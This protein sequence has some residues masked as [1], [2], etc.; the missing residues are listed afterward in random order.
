MCLD[1]GATFPRGVAAERG[2]DGFSCPACGHGAIRGIPAQHSALGTEANTECGAC[3]ATF[4]HGE[5]KTPTK[6]VLA[7]PV[8]GSTSDLRRIDTDGAA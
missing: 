8:C 1:C 4:P 6:G 7:C 5:A 3:G 2:G